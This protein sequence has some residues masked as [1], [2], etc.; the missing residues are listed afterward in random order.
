MGIK[1]RCEKGYHG[2]KR[3]LK[4]GRKAIIISTN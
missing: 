4:M 2:R 1:W 3:Y